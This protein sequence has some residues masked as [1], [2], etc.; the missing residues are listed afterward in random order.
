[1]TP[2][3]QRAREAAKE[4]ANFTFTGDGRFELAERL[5]PVILRYLTAQHAEDV[6]AGEKDKARLDWLQNSP[7]LSN[8][9]GEWGVYNDNADHFHS[10]SIR[11]AIDAAMPAA[12]PTQ[13]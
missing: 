6:A 2:I 1:M 13:P 8:E 12:H 11:L 10:P 5:Y 3:D 4:L 7:Q 9:D